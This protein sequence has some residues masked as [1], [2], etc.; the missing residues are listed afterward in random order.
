ME[1]VSDIS[2]EFVVVILTQAEA[3]DQ[4]LVDVVLRAV[5]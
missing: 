4:E 3:I 2:L 1:S 5:V